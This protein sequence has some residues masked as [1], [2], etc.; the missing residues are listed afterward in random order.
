MCEILGRFI[1]DY[2]HIWIYWFKL[3]TGYFELHDFFVENYVSIIFNGFDICYPCFINSIVTKWYK[4]PVKQITNHYLNNNCL[5]HIFSLSC[6]NTAPSW[7][8]FT[9]PNLSFRENKHLFERP[10]APWELKW[11]PRFQLISLLPRVNFVFL[12][13]CFLVV[14]GAFLIFCEFVCQVS[15]GVS[16]YDWSTGAR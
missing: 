16:F 5:Y 6:Y 3:V 11:Q 13:S 4:L 14:I 1:Q 8:L 9:W 10:D 15:R 2:V 12:I 7:Y